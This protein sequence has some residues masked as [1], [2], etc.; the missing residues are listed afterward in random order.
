ML[1]LAWVWEV[2][3]ADTGSSQRDTPKA[4]VHL[5]FWIG[6][7]PGIVERVSTGVGPGTLPRR[8]NT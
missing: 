8:T 2:V 4:R 6:A 7:V 5:D 1:V 3:A